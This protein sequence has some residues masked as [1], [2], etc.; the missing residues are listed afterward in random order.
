[1]NKTTLGELAQRV[2][3]TIRAA[4]GSDS[5][6]EDLAS[7][8]LTGAA[9]AALAKSGEITF[10]SSAQHL[11]KLADSCA[12]AVVV[13]PNV[14]D[15]PLPAIEV[16]SSREAF[17]EIVQY[18][19]PPITATTTG[20]SSQ[21]Y[22]ASTAEVDPE[23]VVFPGAYIGEHV[24]IGPRAVIHSGVRILDACR[25]AEDVVLFPNVVLYEQTV[26]GART[27][28]HAGTVIGAYGFGYDFIDGRHQ[29]G[30][31][32][33]HVEIECDV[34]IGAC[35]SVDRGTYEATRIGE[36]SKLDDQVMIAHNCQIG[37]HNV[38]CSQVGIAG[39]CVTGDYV[40]MGGQVGMAD[41][42]TIGTGARIGAKSGLMQDIP[43][44]ETHIGIPAI[45][46]REFWRQLVTVQKLNSTNKKIR[47]LER[48]LEQLKS[49]L[50]AGRQQEAA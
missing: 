46:E 45:P 13:E 30:E 25:I 42:L 19:R 20:H 9:T 34:E 4:A 2:H 12:S 28:I 24:T 3:G 32:L 48:E 44:G 18:F 33:G 8:P 10:A 15:L 17:A 35:A 39:S 29:R 49:A 47:M 7:L 50:Q 14:G 26:I 40:V 11:K 1:M 37:K 41:H 23:A 21:A 6:A 22:I 16:P 31:Q 43:A 38:L 27:V 36:G 5:T